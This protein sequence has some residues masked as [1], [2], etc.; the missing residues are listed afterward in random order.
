MKKILLVGFFLA[1][2]TG[3]RLTY[4]DLMP[5]TRE[6][7]LPVHDAY[8]PGGFTSESDAYVVET[9][10]FP[11]GCYSFSRATVTN[12]DPFTHEIKTYALV[13]TG[14][15]PMIMAPYNH[16]VGLGKLARGTHKVLFMSGEGTYI[17]K[18]LTIE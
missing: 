8:I 10:Y 2:A 4:A 6:V 17:E 16:E 3:L 1:S 7:A 11:N 9:G 5:A 13:R 12:K 18:D 15:C 14:L